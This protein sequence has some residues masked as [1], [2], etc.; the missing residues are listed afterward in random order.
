M[1]KARF[2]HSLSYEI[3]SSVQMAGGL[4]LVQERVMRLEALVGVNPD[5]TH[6]FVDQ[7]DAVAN[8]FL[9]LKDSHEKHVAEFATHFSEMLDDMMM[10]SGA[11]K[12]K[13]NDVVSKISLVKK[14]V[15][16]SAHGPNVSHRVR[17]LEPKSFGGARSAKELENFVWDI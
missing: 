16:G 7:L 13:F 10:L 9:S 15:A 2:V 3:D 4:E 8:G 1:F 5:E 11:L 6:S 14:I 17:V 12:E